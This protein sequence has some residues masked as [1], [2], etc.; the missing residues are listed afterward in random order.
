MKDIIFLTSFLR[1]QGQL[2]FIPFVTP[3]I[4]TLASPLS[5][6]SI[7][8]Y[9]PNGTTTEPSIRNTPYWDTLFCT[10]YCILLF[11]SLSTTVFQTILQK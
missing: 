8:L 7:Q 10:A 9:L 5:N 6:P 1:Y 4:F 3:P 11:N 2:L